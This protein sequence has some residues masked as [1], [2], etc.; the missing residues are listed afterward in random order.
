MNVLSLSIL[1]IL[2]QEGITPWFETNEKTY[3]GEYMYTDF[4]NY[5]S[6]EYLIYKIEIQEGVGIYS[7]FLNTEGYSD[8][9]SRFQIDSIVCNQLYSEE[10]GLF[11][12]DTQIDFV[13]DFPPD[14]AKGPVKNGL[15]IGELFFSKL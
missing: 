10:L 7:S 1:F 13:R 15:M 14:N 9:C 8:N 12:G 6:G 2:F 3:E 11:L 5:S 4:S